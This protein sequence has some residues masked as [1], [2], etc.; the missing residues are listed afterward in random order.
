MKKQ[1]ITF[2]ILLSVFVVLG[3]IYYF[4]LK[5]YNSLDNN[6]DMEEINTE[7]ILTDKEPNNLKEATLISQN[8]ELTLIPL[9]DDEDNIEWKIK[10]YEDVLFNQTNMTSIVST[11]TNLT[12]SDI[13]TEKVDNISDF[14]LDKPIVTAKAVFD[15]EE[16]ITIY[17]GDKTVDEKY[18]YAKTD[19]S[20]RIYIL[21]NLYANRLQSKLNGLIDKSINMISQYKILYLNVKSKGNEEIDI[22]YSENK[23]GNASELEN[24]GMQTLRMNK[25]FNGATVYPTNLQDNVLGNLS[26][27]ILNELIEVYPKD[28]NKYGLESPEMEITM[29]D[30]DYD[31]YLKIGNAYDSD[32]LYCMVNQR[33]HVFT[34]N[35]SAIEP[36]T[37]IN[38]F[39]FIEK[40][41]ALNYRVNVESIDI[42]SPKGNY[43]ITFSDD[44]SEENIEEKNVMKDNRKGFI[45]GQ[46]LD[47]DSFSEFYELL[48]GITFDNIDKNY[49]VSGEPVVSIKYNLKDGSYQNINFYEYDNSFYLADNG[50]LDKL[51]V[52]KH[53]VDIMLDKAKQ[54]L[55]S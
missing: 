19:K 28:L 49:S 42:N 2:I 22:E 48:I 8:D 37:N 50:K 4:W 39:D 29:K 31:V 35:K 44:M 25:P 55:E 27:I 11:L 5:D 45:N 47:N 32:N 10:G 24:L 43:K 54:L 7:L 3:C 26:S 1:K 46:E 53:N 15:N 34:I 9:K 18:Y 30:D 17:I 6:A 51:V 33:P 40:F 38:V 12:M 14:G 52:H 16:K 20:D 21:E 36:F 13:I 23:E 41:V